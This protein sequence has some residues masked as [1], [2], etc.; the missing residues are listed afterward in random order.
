MCR[1]SKGSAVHNINI[2][3]EQEQET[4]IEVVN[5]NS[6]ISNSKHFSI[7]VNIKTSLNKVAITL[8]YKFEIGIDGNMPFYIFKKHFLGQQWNS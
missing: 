3:D 4:D 6:V 1:S 2:E 5:I 7:S 8:A